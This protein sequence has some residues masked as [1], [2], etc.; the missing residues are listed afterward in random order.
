[1][2]RRAFIGL[3]AAGCAGLS[4][5]PT[6]ALAQKKPARASKRSNGLPLYD[7]ARQ[8]RRNLFEDFL[9]FMDRH[10]IDHELGGFMCYTDYTG[11][12][13]NDNKSSWFEGR[14]SWAYGFL[15]NNLARDKK[16]LDVARRSIDLVL[17]SKPTSADELWSKEL[18]RDGK[19]ITPPDIEVYGDLFVAEG[20]AE[21]SKATGE[22]SLW[23]E[24]KSLVLKCVRIYDRADYRPSIGQTY[25]GKNARPFPGARIQGVWMVL[26]RVVTQMLMMRKDP[27]LEKVAARSVEAILDRH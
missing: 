23:D 22:K 20:L 7:L 8:Y 27:D 25:L 4:G 15:Y 10:V 1:M 26:I 3:T 17:R 11:T 19:P 21:L 6:M 5:G 16:Y 9:P 2:N 13:E 14:G 24:A 18:T 12:R